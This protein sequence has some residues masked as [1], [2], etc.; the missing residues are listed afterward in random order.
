[1]EVDI[2]SL[3]LDNSDS[4]SWVILLSVA[5]PKRVGEILIQKQGTGR[6]RGTEQERNPARE[7]PP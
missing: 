2:L 1:M 5:P 7:G 4:V 3:L 6:K